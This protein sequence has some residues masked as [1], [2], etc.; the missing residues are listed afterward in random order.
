MEINVIILRLLIKIL[1]IKNS[2]VLIKCNTCKC[3][4]RPSI[5]SHINMK[6]G[7]PDCLGKGCSQVALDWL[8]SIEQQQNI[9]IQ[10]HTSPDGEFKIPSPNGGYYR[11]DGYHAST[12]TIYEYHGDYWHGNPKRYNLNEHNQKAGK[13]FE[14]LYIK[15]IK[16]ED[17]LKL[18]GYNL[19]VKWET[20]FDVHKISLSF[21]EA[22]AKLNAGDFLIFNFSLEYQII[23]HDPI[24]YIATFYGKDGNIYL[25]ELQYNQI[26]NQ[27]YPPV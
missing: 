3:Q 24:N 15:T 18:L 21:Y 13:T 5:I 9:V 22:V 6:R 8:K 12:N 14:E 25:A 2:R 23:P 4:W 10:C 1:L 19:I 17:Y 11:A 7:C 27:I 26:T 20:P 16:K